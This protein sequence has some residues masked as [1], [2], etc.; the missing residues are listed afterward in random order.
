M[1]WGSWTFIGIIVAIV[2]WLVSIYNRLVALRNRFKNAWAQ[3]DVQLKRRY[4]LIP[5]LVETTKGYLKH[6]RGTLEAVIAARNSAAAAVVGGAL[7]VIGGRTVSDGNTPAVEVYDPGSD[8][9]EDARPMPKAQAGLAASVLNGKIYV[10]GGETSGAGGGV[11]P[12]AWE[13]NPRADEWRAV[14]AMARPRHGLGAVTLGNAVYVLGG[15]SK[16]GAEETSA[17]LD[18]F[19]I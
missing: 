13:Y 7:Y 1:G 8:R 3:I 16:A 11:F 18:K 15:A 17:A 5:N 9:W 14:A 10:F 19:E 6:E 2:V 12:D 4:D